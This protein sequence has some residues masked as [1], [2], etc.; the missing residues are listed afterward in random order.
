MPAGMKGVALEEPPQAEIGAL[1]GAE[2]LH[3]LMR[4][5]GA[6]GQEA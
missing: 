2:A 4:I 5:G 1:A 6:G 3:R